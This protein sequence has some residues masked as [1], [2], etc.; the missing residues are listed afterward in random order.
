LSLPSFPFLRLLSCL[1]S[2]SNFFVHLLNNQLESGAMYFLDLGLIPE[3]V[4]PQSPFL[5]AR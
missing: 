4:I 2:N 5:V 3:R 1:N